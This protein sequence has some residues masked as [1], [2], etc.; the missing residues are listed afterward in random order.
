MRLLFLAA[1]QLCC[2]GFMGATASAD[3]WPSAWSDLWRTP[4]Q[5]GQALLAAGEPGQAAARFQDP[6]R[7][8]YAYLE[9][10]RYGDAAALLAPFNDSESEY[11]RGNALAGSGQL[12]AAL[13]AYDAALKLAPADADI[14]HNRDLVEH[15][16]RQRQQSA[17]SRPGPQRP[18]AS[19]PQTPANGQMGANGS[20]AGADRSG[21]ASQRPNAPQ[22][23]AVRRAGNSKDDTDEARRDAAFAAANARGMRQPSS[24]SQTQSPDAGSLAA[25]GTETPKEQPESE[26]QLMLDQ[27]LRQIPDSPA[28]LLQ[29]QFLIDHMTRQQGGGE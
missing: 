23:S 25:G 29:R 13:A 27:W 18:R 16:L 24:P 15:A 22:A 28:G 21:G 19:S 12:Q 26:R 10:R 3:G 17:Q 1:A 9:A 14:R 4:D 2:A 8:A 6:R 5:Q 11:N 7:R 20:Q